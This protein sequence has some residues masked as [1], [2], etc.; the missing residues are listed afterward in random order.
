MGRGIDVATQD[1]TDEYLAWWVDSAGKVIAT[2]DTGTSTFSARMTLA[3]T[4]T[5]T[6]PAAKP[7]AAVHHPGLR[8]FRLSQVSDDLFEAFRNM[9]LAF[10]LL[11]SSRYPKTQRSESD[12]LRASLSAASGDLLL[13]D[14][15]PPGHSSPVD[16]VIDTIYGNAR[17]PLFHAK[18]GKTYVVP[19]PDERHR[20][21]VKAA[22]AKLTII[23][24]RMADAWHGIRRPRTSLSRTAQDTILKAP[25]ENASFV[26]SSDA[27]FSPSDPLS[28]PSIT[29]GIRFPARASDTFDG[30]QRMNVSG[31][32]STDT[33]KGL[34]RI[35]ILHLVN[36]ESP[37]SWSV[38]KAPLNVHGFDRFE[39][40]QFFRIVGAGEPRIFYPR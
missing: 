4:G 10:E 11:L 28:S 17:L 27:R 33:L 39:A 8:F 13:Q 40:I 35:E 36:A 16:F 34:G 26:A 30:E 5:G 22:L 21:S 1:A 20:A 32:V 9:Y 24:I 19:S 31:S 14:L 29:S 38:F 12:W 25:F 37:L 7:P 18:D 23:V 6:A 2:V 3:T 15:A